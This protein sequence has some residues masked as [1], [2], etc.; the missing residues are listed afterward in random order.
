MLSPDGTVLRRDLEVST[1]D[2]GSR[3]PFR[4]D[5]YSWQRHCRGLYHTPIG[6]VIL[7]IRH[8]QVSNLFLA[9][10]ASKPGPASSPS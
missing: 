4:F 6:R 1:P 7:R 3:F 9:I 8:G 10:R 5:S 2:D